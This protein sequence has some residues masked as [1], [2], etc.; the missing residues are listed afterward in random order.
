VGLSLFL[1]TSIHD[2][3]TMDDA[4]LPNLRCPLDHTRQATLSREDQVLRCS[5]CA[6]TF[7]IKQGL[8]I[9]LVDE[10]ILPPHIQE[11]SG[12]PCRKKRA[13]RGAI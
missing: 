6:V 9:L 10:A 12:L 3:T 8:P 13:L 5:Q 2:N 4:F 11:V 1:H 7:P